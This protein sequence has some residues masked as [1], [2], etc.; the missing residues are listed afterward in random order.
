MQITRYLKLLPEYTLNNKGFRRY[1]ANTS[2]MLSEQM[3]RLVAG[4]L[5]G[6]WVARYLGPERFGV[7][8]YAI[9]FVAIFGIVAKLGLDGIVVR[10]LIH[11]PASI[12]IYLGTTFWLKVIGAFITLTVIILATFLTT[13]DHI[14]NLY[15]FIIACG[16]IF[17]SFE[18]IDFYFQ[19]KVLSKFVSLCKMSQLAISSILKLYFVFTGAD[20]I[21]FVLVSLVDQITLAFTLC[22]AYRFKG[23]SLFYFHFDYEIA[24]KLLRESWIL[25]FS[26]LFTLMYMR[27]DQIIL[28]EIL[29]SREVGIYSV[30]VRLSEV[31]YLLPVV[32]VNSLF[33]AIAG[34]KKVNEEFYYNRLQRLFTFMTYQ[35]IFIALFITF[36]GHWLVEVLYGKVYQEA[37]QVLIIQVWANVFVFLGLAGGKWYLTESLFNLVFYRTLLGVVFNIILN[38]TLIPVY[39][40]PGAAISAVITHL[41]TGLLFDLLSRKT[42]LIFFM[43][44]KSLDFISA[45]RMAPQARP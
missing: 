16:L 31:W 45:I 30:A 12:D 36:T 23:I 15:I 6:I 13:N 40:L 17:Q 9:S 8:N 10:D 7:L 26:N 28:K 34:A 43:K 5:V 20:I 2:W 39:G 42:R 4:L 38:L 21:A 11:N 33:P 18:V 22:I 41:I 19:S 14:T 44:L 25:I 1:F 35:A 29:S 24:K 27:L 3:L 37:G 32:I